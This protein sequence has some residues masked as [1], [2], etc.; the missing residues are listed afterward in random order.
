MTVYI[1][2]AGCGNSDLLTGRASSMAE[3]CGII[4]GP[5]RLV[6]K[7]DGFKKVYYEY[8]AKKIKEIIDRENKDTAVFMS[9]DT[10]IYSGTKR[11]M[12]VLN[13]YK[14][15][16]IPG[17]STVSYF[18]SKINIPWQEWK[19]ISIHGRKSNVIGHIRE[20][21]YTFMFLN[22]AVDVKN[23]CSKLVSYGLDNV[24]VY[25]GYDLSYESEEIIE[26]FSKDIDF[27]ERTSLA[28]A[29]FVNEN[30]KKIYG[31]IQ[32]SE[33]IRGSVPMTK[34]EIRTISLSKLG[35]NADSVLYDVGAGTGSVSVAAAMIDPEIKVYAIEKNRDALELIK[36][37]K[38]KFC[39]DNIEIIHGEAPEV[40]DKIDE[41]PTHVFI[42]GS[43]RKMEN[44]V[45][46]IIKKN[47]DAK[48]VVNAVTPETL[49]ET[50]KVCQKIKRTPDIVQIFAARGEKAGSS[51]IMRAL[52]PVYI[53]SF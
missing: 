19:I 46:R 45:D 47:N 32:D 43:G 35:L 37:N 38:T 49:S 13:G 22:G 36:A 30:H 8:K 18:S 25:A 12:D 50:L 41:I 14:V 52:N 34:S 27:S 5:E 29:L 53:I 28:A 21:K 17:I 9:G 26:G 11:L 48:F 16:V 31:E 7:Y 4:I 42:G 6:K 10:G 39:A 33:F 15:E 2:G 40:L 44:I 1:I 3:K 20:N 23:I 51:T 24:Y